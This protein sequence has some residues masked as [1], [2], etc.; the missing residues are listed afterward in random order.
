MPGAPAAWVV[1]TPPVPL[2]PPPPPQPASAIAASA[3]PMTLR[4]LV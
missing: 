4:A 3:T 2:A 1:V